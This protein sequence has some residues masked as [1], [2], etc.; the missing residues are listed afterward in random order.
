VIWWPEEIPTLTA[1]SDRS[2]LSFAITLRP[3][4][5][6]DAE[7]IYRGA[8]DPEVPKFTTLPANYSLDNAINFAKNRAPE[9]HANRLELIFA[10]DFN[11]IDQYE[12][13]ANLLESSAN[14]I[15]SS[16][17][18]I[19]KPTYSSGQTELE[20][21]NPQLAGIIS[22]H[23]I[24]F[25]NHRAEIGYWLVKEARNKGVGTASVELLT[26]YGLMTM[27]FRRIDALVDNRNEPSKR[28]LE[29][30]GYQFEGLL[31]NYVTRPDGS[32]ID[33]AIFAA[34]TK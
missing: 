21:N 32:Q 20:N 15:E 7:A 6:S 27:G 23:S 22:L 3:V 17:N 18:Q 26:D 25:A 19:G 33:M 11:L 16:A 13:S 9:R 1:V 5:P 34:T 31:K 2:P 10:I 30:A 12:K 4:V 8:Q 29:K 28:L 14:L 24:D